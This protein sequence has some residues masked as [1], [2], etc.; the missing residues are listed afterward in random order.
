M[1]ACVFVCMCSGLGEPA[2]N[3]FLDFSEC[4]DLSLPVRYIHFQ[5]LSPAPVEGG[6]CF[7]GATGVLVVSGDEKLSEKEQDNVKMSKGNLRS[8]GLHQCKKRWSSV[9]FFSV[10]LAAQAHCD[11]SWDTMV[12]CKVYTVLYSTGAP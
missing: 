2:V 4:V 5:W 3:P 8:V 9:C 7:C 1:R 6:S 11:P 10:K 12:Q